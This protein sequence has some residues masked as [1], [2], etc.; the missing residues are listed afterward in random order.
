MVYKITIT[1]SSYDENEGVSGY[2]YKRKIN[3]D[4]LGYMKETDFTEIQN[5]K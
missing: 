4:E 2:E 5:V 3:S 1:R